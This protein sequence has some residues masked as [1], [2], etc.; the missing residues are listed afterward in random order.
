MYKYMDVWM[1]GCMDV[2]MHV[3]RHY[4]LLYYSSFD[5]FTLWNNEAYGERIAK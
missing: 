1:Y 5:T 2:C 4:C 3:D